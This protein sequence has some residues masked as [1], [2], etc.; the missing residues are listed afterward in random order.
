M[1]YSIRR[2]N[3]A[4]G[5][6]L[7]LAV[8]LLAMLMT[9]P[10]TAA[11]ASGKADGIIRETFV[12]LQAPALEVLK[13]TTRLDMLDYWDADSIY[14][15]TN[16]Q[17]GKSWI[18]AFTPTYMK[19]RVTPVST[20]ELKLLPLKKG[21]VIMAIFTVGDELQAEDSEIDFYDL[22]L[23]KLDTGKYFKA[24]DLSRFFDIPKGSLTSMS[25]IREMIPFPT[26][27]YSASPDSDTL[28]GRLT[29]DKFM[30]IDNY[31]IMKIFLKPEITLQWKG[32]YQ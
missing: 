18:E 17:D 13:K 19:V 7:S 25:E 20:Y 9:L 15:A 3:K 27:S 5:R 11:D 31:N 23:Q 29:V 16:A 6:I 21:N 28:T 1:R 10:A 26:V 30:D 24:P 4:S 14:K 22:S 12:N 8:A 2:K 32:K